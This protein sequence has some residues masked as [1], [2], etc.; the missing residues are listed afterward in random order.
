MFLGRARSLAVRQ[1]TLAFGFNLRR[2]RLASGGFL[3]PPRLLLADA[4]LEFAALAFLVGGAA[5]LG[6]ARGGLRSLHR[7]PAL[8]LQRQ[9]PLFGQVEFFPERRSF[10]LGVERVVQGNLLNLARLLGS[11]ANHRADAFLAR[12]LR[13]PVPGLELALPLLLGAFRLLQFPL[14]SEL[15]SPHPV[16]AVNL[17]LHARL[18]GTLV[19]LPHLL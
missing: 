11:L 9:P 6:G 7:A 18:P 19:P 3:R 12:L 2:R 17:E 14:R 8:L 13:A 10:V 15:P 1:L 5:L 16:R 4:L